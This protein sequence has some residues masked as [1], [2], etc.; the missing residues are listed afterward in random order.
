MRWDPWFPVGFWEQ[1]FTKDRFVLRV[2]NQLVNQIFDFSRF[3]DPRVAFSGTGFTAPMAAMPLPGPGF[4]TAFEWWPI[5]GSPLY[6]VGTVNLDPAVTPPPVVLP[7]VLA[8][9]RQAR[10]GR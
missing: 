8:V 6:V 2:G 4:A 7:R 5:G 9:R 10:C 1:W 3:K